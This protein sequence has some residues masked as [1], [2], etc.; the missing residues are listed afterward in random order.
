MRADQVGANDLA[1]TGTVGSAAG[2]FSNAADFE[3]SSTDTL[4]LADNATISTG[5]IDFMLRCWIKIESLAATGTIIIKGDTVTTTCDYTIYV[6]SAGN[7]NFRVMNPGASAFTTVTWSAALST[8]TWY[9]VHAWHDAT[10]NVIGIA[11]N[12]GTAVTQA[13]TEGVRDS[14]ETFALGGEPG[15][16]R[17]Y[18]GLIDDALLMKNAFLDATERTEDYNSGTGI[19]FEN[20]AAP[21]N[22]KRRDLMLLGVGC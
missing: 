21:A 12:A 3:E 20:W 16:G 14:A 10:G 11:V 1:D 18:D 2:M 7:L 19:A 5:D 6:D 15:G 17:Y 13:F 22:T 8:A 4:T 9:L